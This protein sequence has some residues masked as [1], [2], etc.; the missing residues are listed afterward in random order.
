MRA[1]V[2]VSGC[3]AWGAMPSLHALLGEGRDEI[4]FD[5]H[6]ARAVRAP[7]TL[8]RLARVGTFTVGAALVDGRIVA[9]VEVA[10]TQTD[11]VPRG[12][13]L[14]DAHRGETVLLMGVR[15]VRVGSFEAVS[16]DGTVEHEGRSIA[17][18]HVGKLLDELERLAWETRRITRMPGSAGPAAPA[19]PN[20]ERSPIT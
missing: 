1:G 18:A 10:S 16:G 3:Q 17:I 19:G 9:A 8:R 7:S 12:I 13:L 15:I 6:D 5:A 2:V 11:V 14:V 20:E 4:F